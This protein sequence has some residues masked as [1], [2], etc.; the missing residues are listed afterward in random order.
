MNAYEFNTGEVFL[1]ESAHDAVQMWRVG[2]HAIG[3]DSDEPRRLKPR[4][5]VLGIKV[6]EW[7]QLEARGLIDRAGFG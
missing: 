7:C 4:D 6:R 3:L 2:T 1:A 5:V